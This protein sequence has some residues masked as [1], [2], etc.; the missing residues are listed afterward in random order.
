MAKKAKKTTNQGKSTVTTENNKA[1][2]TAPVDAAE[3]ATPAAEETTDVVGD[4]A[5]AS[6]EAV[7]EVEATVTETAPAPTANT[8]AA[9]IVDESMVDP[10]LR[11]ALNLLKTQFDDYR[12]NMAKGR[13]LSD[14]Q[15]V[16]YQ[17][18][19]WSILRSV[20]GKQGQEFKVLF[21][22]LLAL[23]HSESTGCLDP[24]YRYR[25]F[26]LLAIGAR[27]ARSFESIL[28]ALLTVANPQERTLRLKQV[29]FKQVFDRY[30][31]KAALD[32]VTDYFNL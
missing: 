15:G 5:E 23:L 19:L 28:S 18:R 17:T 29:D 25:F 20:L 6:A 21:G 32:R 30:D 13:P 8:K 26:P 1:E 9:G 7:A 2:E 31:D 22:Q 14:K 11:D 24:R 10:K 16:E 4:Q 12:E 3:Q 27:Q